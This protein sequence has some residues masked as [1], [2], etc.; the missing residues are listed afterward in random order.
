ML[1]FLISLFIHCL[2]SHSA[3]QNWLVPEQLA[4]FY[5]LFG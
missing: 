2:V 3:S 5:F 4:I 1:N